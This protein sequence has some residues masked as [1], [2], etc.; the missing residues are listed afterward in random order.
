MILMEIYN[1]FGWVVRVCESWPEP[2]CWT[3]PPD[4]WN[5]WRCDEDS[6][7]KAQKRSQAC[8]FVLWVSG[9]TIT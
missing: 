6:Y 8:V 7:S 2:V 1:E 3:S 9:D 4:G 5:E